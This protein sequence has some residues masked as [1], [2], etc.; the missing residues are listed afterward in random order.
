Q[1]DAAGNGVL[2][3]VLARKGTGQRQRGPRPAVEWHR[4][5]GRERSEGSNR[6]AVGFGVQAGVH[7]REE[8]TAL[9]LGEQ[10]GQDVRGRDGAGAGAARVTG[11]RRES[12]GDRRGDF[13]EHRGSP[14][15]T[16]ETARGGRTTCPARTSPAR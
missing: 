5:A 13:R 1:Q 10:P 16:A 2:A 9:L 8:G 11:G 12:A 4:F 14:R 7:G 3:G 6:A 15:T